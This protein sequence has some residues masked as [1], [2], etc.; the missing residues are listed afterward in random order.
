MEL[1]QIAYRI[2][3]NLEFVLEE[4]TLDVNPFIKVIPD[5]RTS[6]LLKRYAMLSK[7]QMNAR[8]FLIETAPAG[9]EEDEP[10]IML[11]D[12]EVFR[13]QV[14]FSDTRFFNATHLRLYDLTDDVFIV[15]NE[16]DHIVGTELLLSLPLATYNASNEYFPGYVVASGGDF[17]KALQASNNADPHPVVEAAY[18]KLLTEGTCMSQADLQARSALTYP[19]DLDTVI[20]IEIKHTASLNANYQLLDVSAKCRE[21]SYKIKLLKQN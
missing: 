9:A 10:K 16:A 6:E 11:E 18:W 14:K 7:R 21:V 13:F 8:V 15:S 1:I 2:L 19:V 20:V 17:Y 3:F 4:Y 12:D 5:Q